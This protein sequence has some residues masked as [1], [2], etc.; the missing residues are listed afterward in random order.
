MSTYWTVS[1]T[2][3]EENEFEGYLFLPMK[4]D[5]I[6]ECYY[7]LKDADSRPDLRAQIFE[8]VPYSTWI[9]K[10][11]HSQISIFPIM[12]VK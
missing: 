11:A 3:N 9:Q 1:A 2:E 4:V 7:L 5:D 6:L 10:A 12:H 8:S